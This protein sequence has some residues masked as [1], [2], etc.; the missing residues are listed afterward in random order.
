MTRG[1]GRFVAFPLCLPGPYA[2]CPALPTLGLPP[3]AR[4]RPVLERLCYSRRALAHPVLVRI[5]PLD[6]FGKHSPDTDQHFFAG[7]NSFK[8]D[9]SFSHGGIQAGCA[10]NSRAA[11]TIKEFCPLA[12]LSPPIA[13]SSIQKCRE[14]RAIHLLP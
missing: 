4:R 12:S 9:K 6:Q 11:R 7:L 10:F 8:Q 5:E 14:T 1:S 2:K 3:R 13:F